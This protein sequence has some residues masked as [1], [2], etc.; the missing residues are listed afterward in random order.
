MAGVD[1]EQV[2]SNYTAPAQPA[3][4]DGATDWE[5]VGANAGVSPAQ[6]RS[7]LQQVVGTSPDQAA[8]NL[9]TAQAIG[10]PPQTAANLPQEAKALAAQ[11]QFPAEQIAAHS[12]ATA[13]FLSDPSYMG[14]GYDDTNTLAATESAVKSL[15]QVGRSAW[16]AVQQTGAGLGRDLGL[17]AS[18]PAALYGEL[19]GNRRPGDW[20]FQHTVDPF[21]KSLDQLQAGGGTDFSSKLGSTLGG[22]GVQIPTMLL[23]G[24][25]S[26]APEA[27]S[28]LQPLSQFVRQAY[29]RGMSANLIPG[30][31]Q[32]VGDIKQTYGAGHYMATAAAS[33]LAKWFINNAVMSAPVGMEGNFL[34]RA[35]TGAVSMPFVNEAAREASNTVSPADEQS[36]FDPVQAFLLDPLSGGLLAGT[37]GHPDGGSLADHLE[38]VHKANQAYDAHQA[39]QAVDALSQAS[40]VRERAP[41]AFHEFMQTVGDEHGVDNLYVDG[42]KFVQALQ[43]TKTPQADVAK[44]MPEVGKQF[45][46]VGQTEGTVRIPLADYATHLAGTPLGQQLLPHLKVDPEGMTFD[47]AQQFQQSEVERMQKVAEDVTGKQADS[48]AFQES[49]DRAMEP[50]EQQLSAAG[51]SK[52]AVSTNSA[53]MRAS[54]AQFA[55]AHGITPEEAMQRYQL[56]IQRGAA[57]LA[58]REG[59]Y[60][61]F[62]GPTAASANLDSLADAKKQLE[63]GA[64]PEAVRRSTGWFQGADGK[65]RYEITDDEAKFRQHPE[66]TPEDVERGLSEGDITFAKDKDVPT[67]TKARYKDGTPDYMGAFGRTEEEARHNL[68]NHLARRS[69]LRAFDINKVEPGDEKFLDS[70]LEHAKLFQA[71]PGFERLKVQFLKDADFRGAYSEHNARIQLNMT[72]DHAQMLSTLLHEIQH[73]IQSREGFATGGMPDPDFAKSVRNAL[74][75]LENHSKEAVD[76]WKYWNAGKVDAAQKAAEASRYALMYESA[77]RLLEYARRDKPSGVFRLIRNE[78]QWIYDRAF[79]K[80]DDVQQLQRDF[81]AIPKPGRMQARNAHLADMAFRGAQALLRHIPDELRENF[82]NDDRSMKALVAA[83]RREA[84]RRRQELSPLW[85]LEKQARSAQGVAQAHKY[86]SPF[87]IYRALSGEVEARNTQARQKL[88]AEERA[89]T[90]PDSTQD[91]PSE[92]HI[93]MFGGMD[94]QVPSL[95]RDTGG[96]DEKTGLPLNDDGTVTVYHHTSADNAAEIRRTGV[97]KSAG[98]PDLY[99]TTTPETS[100]GYGD[101][102]VPIRVHPDKLQLDDEFPDGRQDYRVSAP[103][104]SRRLKLIG[105]DMVLNQDT[106]RGQVSMAKDVASRPSVISLFE[107]ADPSTVQHE[108]MHWW[109]EVYMHAAAQPDA[110]QRV[111][112]IAAGLL[113]G[114]GVDS[115]DAWHAM[116][117]DEKRDGH[118]QLAKSWEAYLRDGKAPTAELQ[119]VFGKFRSWLVRVYKSIRDL[120]VSVSPELRQTFDRMLASDQAIDEAQ[121]AR[122]MVPM[123]ESKP[124]GMSDEEWQ[125]YLGQH[126]EAT[127]DAKAQLQSRALRD[128]QWISNARDKA[129]RQL[130]R[131]AAAAR[132]GIRE[133]VEKEVGQMPVYRA[134]TFIRT[135]EDPAENLSRAERKADEKIAGG[136]TKL[137]IDALKAMY[138]DAPAAPWRYLDTGARGLAGKDGVHPDILADRLGFNSGDELVK[139]LLDA[140][141]R[142][143]VV[144]GL[145]DQRMLEQHGD[146]ADPVS[147][148]RAAEAA[149]H[150]QV[151][152][153]VLATELKRLTSATGDER[154]IAHASKQAA[155]EKIGQTKVKDLN[156]RLYEVAESRAGRNSMKALGK[157]D[158]LEAAWHKRAQLLNNALARAAGDA[159]AEVDKSLTYLKRLQ[160]STIREKIDVDIRDQIDDLLGRFDLRRN[161]PA[162]DAARAKDVS[163]AQLNL[164]QWVDA[165]VAAGYTPNIPDELLNPTTRMPYNQMTV[166]QFRGLVETVRS[167]EEWGR[168]RNLISI[169]GER[170]ALDE[171]LH[172]QVIPKLQER[173]ARF[174]AEQ[175][176]S[177]VEERDLSRFQ[178]ALERMGS[179]MRALGAE[180]KPQQYKANDYDR[181]EILGPL[182]R[183][184]FNRIFDANYRKMDMLKGMSNQFRAKA[185]ELGREWQDGLNDLVTNS[186]LMD[187]D[188]SAEEGKPVPMKITRGRMLMM[189]LHSGNE[190]NFDKLV[191]GYQWEPAE[192]MKFLGENMTPKDI[193]AVNHIWGLYESHWPE[194]AAMYKRLGQT[195]PPKLAAR[196]FDLPAG[197]LTGGY[198]HIDYHPL[199]S[200]YGQKAGASAAKE[201]ADK[202]TSVGDYFRRTATTN[203][204]MNARLEGYTD[205]IDLDFHTIERA[206]KETIH[207]LAYREALVDTN[208]ILEHPD[209]KREFERAYGPEEL[210]ALHTWLGRIANSNNADR[211]V[212]ALSRV[213]QYTRTGLVMNAIALR[214]ST[215]LKHGG[216]AGIKTG[217]YFV[218]GGERFIASRMAAMA[219][220]YKNQIQGAIEKFP[221]IRARL[222]QQDRDYRETASSLFEHEDWRSKGERFGHAFVAWSDM[223]TAVPTAWAAYDRAITVGIPKSQGGTGAPMGEAEAI[224]Y[225]NKIVREAHGSQLETA[226]SNVM[227]SPN[228]AV[229]MLTTLYGFMNNTYGQMADAAS[230]LR[231]ANYSR[232]EILARSFAAIIVPALW[233][234]VLTQGAPTAENW[235]KW[236]GEAIADEAAGTVPLARDAMSMIKGYEHAGQLPVESWLAT[237][238]APF[239]DVKKIAEGKH[240]PIIQDA[241]N[242]AGAGLHIPGLGQL[243][244]T[245]QYEADVASGRKEQS[246]KKALVGGR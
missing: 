35:A 220:D 188:V 191:K 87:D 82:K 245:A 218:G 233:A 90:P 4:N 51:L 209:F 177:R 23:T 246:L 152:A 77:Q 204:A 110:P 137:D 186:T 172:D 53:L 122:Q 57:D 219:H 37:M 30:M 126:D 161:P 229:K 168:Q 69:N 131:Q 76:L 174:T 159:Q 105:D 63:S 153:R 221:E 231:T 12:P 196:P 22:L 64:N 170:V 66:V 43:A 156:P 93:V 198:A 20:M 59:A 118:E 52:T 10:V 91:I 235:A 5:Q 192:V 27:A 133:Q 21:Q 212:S 107:N 124:E 201:I 73:A 14:L 199:R 121:R 147:I 227:N 85:D 28:A 38:A 207:D 113:K 125:Q 108:L 164:R 15:A 181:H 129:E 179:W 148:R 46:E 114:A 70:V 89:K 144:E 171:F 79:D 67:L 17:A 117:T 178:A 127:E 97:L 240:A 109:T 88:T 34:K 167:M 208:K 169:E 96:V 210:K 163:R 195:L 19:T 116:S 202:G 65:W 47:D 101:V 190:S 36:K 61:Q 223:M 100:T 166:E 24:G 39:L 224:Q 62:A 183:A 160:R 154:V 184:L 104:R 130:N 225:A 74:D 135:G 99:F 50:L 13:S 211:D 141:P 136:S 103:A 106:T 41:E 242:A 83:F 236:V 216:S 26:A 86:S 173:G 78:M 185:E 244:K 200:R 32:L 151:R 115:L 138:G 84:S 230:K 33:A 175:R 1:W 238:V 42:D 214:I 60:N 194:M 134:E 228:E 128:A 234:G 145:T 111:K 102:A 29:V 176:T 149:I 68:I 140:E 94:V 54:L 81:Y 187:P 55:D 142:K 98:E 75:R 6:L 213:L 72:G 243:G 3:S 95:R 157:G 11:K 9:R 206:L 31:T 189:A 92:H 205:A 182:S 123:F 203:G 162:T 180:L 239:V 215:V 45:T 197:H 165:Q 193:D 7:N 18:A 48:D 58:G 232:P 120:G 217:G 146:L 143:S 49:M 226:R 56:A 139:A 16:N 40:K 237:M 241:A 119:S 150:N 44:L 155:E 71:Y 132:R 2:G 222:M 8:Q 25:E 80:D 112:D 158:T